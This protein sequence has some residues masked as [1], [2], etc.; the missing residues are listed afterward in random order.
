MKHATT[1]LLAAALMGGSA[2][3]ASATDLHVILCGD[4]RPA[5]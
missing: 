2:M 1:L 5:D 4:A 3:A